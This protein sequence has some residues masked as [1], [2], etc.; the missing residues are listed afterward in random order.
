MP[1]IN[2]KDLKKYLSGIKNKFSPVYLIYGEEVLYKTAFNDILDIL[3]PASERS[4]KYE[5]IDNDSGIF[6]VF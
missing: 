6:R 1:E 5:P 4:M 3:L 2:Y